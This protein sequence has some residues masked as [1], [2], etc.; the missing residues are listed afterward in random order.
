MALT[1]HNQPRMAGVARWQDGLAALHARI[2]PRFRRPE[3]RARAG[4]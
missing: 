2:A 3:A 1:P 4:R